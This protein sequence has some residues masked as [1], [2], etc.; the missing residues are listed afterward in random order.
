M[1]PEYVCVASTASSI[2]FITSSTATIALVLRCFNVINTVVL[3]MM[4]VVAIITCAVIAPEMSRLAEHPGAINYWLK[5]GVL[6]GAVS[7]VLTSL[8]CIFSSL[9]NTRKRRGRGGP[10]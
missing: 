3:M 5:N 1:A 6:I 10:A 7:A 2:L 8:L 9:G 4:S